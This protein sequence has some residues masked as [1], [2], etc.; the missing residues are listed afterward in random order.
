MCRCHFADNCDDHDLACPESAGNIALSLPAVVSMKVC[1]I[2]HKRIHRMTRQPDLQQT[3]SALL[4]MPAP[5]TD[6]T[7]P[8]AMWVCV[9]LH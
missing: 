6:Q 9:Q 4:L 7:K 1:S 8:N 3:V 2:L 5:L